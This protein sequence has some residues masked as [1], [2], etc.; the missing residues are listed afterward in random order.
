MSLAM[1]G[2]VFLAGAGTIGVAATQ[3]AAGG[4]AH[5]ATPAVATSSAAAPRAVVGPITVQRAWSRATPPG[6]SVGVAYFDIVNTGAA[7][8]L[9]G[10]ESAVAQRVEM[11][12]TTLSGGMMQMRQAESVTIPASGQ[13]AFSPSG[14]HA[15]LLQLKQPLK[16]GARIPLILIFRHA[17]RVPAV[18]VVQGLDADTPPVAAA[19]T[20][21]APATPAP[22][23]VPAPAAAALHRGPA[24]YRLAAWPR[25]A[26]SPD[27]KLVDTDGRARTLTDYRGRVVVLFFGFVH[28]PDVCPAELFTLSAVMKKLGPLGD[29]VQVL[30]VTLDPARDTRKLL[31]G[32]VK[33]FDHRFVGLTGSPSQIDAAANSFF[34]EYAKVGTGADYTLDH[35]TSTFLLD[36]T[37]RLRLVGAMNTS[38]DNYTHDLTALAS[39]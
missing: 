22:A 18:A 7:D 8:E 31:D 16:E 15:M 35:S 1:I 28:C 12:A 34:V 23:A 32:Y 24:A 27:F 33:A 25:R 20:A 11:H 36:A 14:L 9:V 3:A 10:M 2:A 30:F 17:G 13:V 29:R 38:I 21:S 6:T 19:P 37:G 4:A 5:V 26:Q 39:E